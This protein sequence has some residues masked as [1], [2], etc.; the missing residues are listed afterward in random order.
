M[1]KAWWRAAFLV[2]ATLSALAV[3]VT[4]A[5]QRA[6]AIVD[7]V[8]TGAVPADPAAIADLLSRSAS[9]ADNS[10]AGACSWAIAAFWLVGIVDAYR[11]GKM[12]ER[13]EEA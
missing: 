7:D 4:V 3:V 1:L 8:M 12:A 13:V 2:L 10:L 5:T 9:G 11:V 6:M